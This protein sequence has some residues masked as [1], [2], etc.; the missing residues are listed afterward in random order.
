MAGELLKR[1]FE[2]EL[3][4]ERL[5][6]KLENI[7]GK[8]PNDLK[9]VLFLIGVQELGK[10][11]RRFTKEEKRDLMHIA[12][13]RVLS[14]SGYYELEGLDEAGWPHWKAQKKVPHFDVIEQ[15]KLLKIHI[16]EYFEE[17]RLLEF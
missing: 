13:C 15:E 12:I 8:K 1:D 14:S 2:N 17:E 16:M 11:A 7:I 9:A 4:W 3:K 5:L 10:G 6:Q